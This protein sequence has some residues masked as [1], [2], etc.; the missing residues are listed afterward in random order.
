MKYHLWAHIQVSPPQN[1]AQNHVCR[2]VCHFVAASRQW[3]SRKGLLLHKAEQEKDSGT[4]V[5][6]PI[7][8]MA[9]FTHHGMPLL[10][11]CILSLGVSQISL[12][13]SDLVVLVHEV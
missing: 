6:G 5:I 3:D 11:L 4:P 13:D 10:E 7:K 2:L 1:V 12:K 9:V 8:H